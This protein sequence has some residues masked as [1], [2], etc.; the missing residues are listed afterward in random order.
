MTEKA[1]C[2]LTVEDLPFGVEPPA[3]MPLSAAV[4]PVFETIP[5]SLDGM[6]PGPILGAFLSSVKVSK[7]SGHDQIV[8]LRAHQKMA[9]F[10]Q[11]ATY[12]DMAA[13]PPFKGDKRG[14]MRRVRGITRSQRHPRGRLQ[15]SKSRECV[16][17]R[18]SPCIG[19]ASLCRP[20]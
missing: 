9:S 16:L 14:A 3:G 20:P 12:R 15:S 4:E 5:R 13:R 11:A 19:T 7:L 17:Y 8:V 2:G 6:A 18:G 10:Y 1:Y